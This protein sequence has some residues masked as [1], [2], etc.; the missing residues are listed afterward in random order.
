[1]DSKKF[2]EVYLSHS[3]ELARQELEWGEFDRRLFSAVAVDTGLSVK[4]VKSLHS[5]FHWYCFNQNGGSSFRLDYHGCN[6]NNPLWFNHKTCET[7]VKLVL[8]EVSLTA[9]VDGFLSAYQPL[10]EAKIA[11]LSRQS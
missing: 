3:L 1:M 4:E 8:P 9:L 7:R 10:L 11:R 5:S 6:I 2:A